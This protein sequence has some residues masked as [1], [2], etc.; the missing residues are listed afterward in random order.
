MIGSG[1]LVDH[2]RLPDL[3]VQPLF[4]ANIWES[5]AIG[6]SASSAVLR[7]GMA[8]ARLHGGVSSATA[9]DQQRP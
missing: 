7:V 9:D 2:A 5:V 3:L 4:W 8:G 1:S 6:G